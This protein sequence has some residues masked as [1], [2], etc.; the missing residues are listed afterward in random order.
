[1]SVG[2]WW[3]EF[4]WHFEQNE[5]M[6]SVQEQA[7]IKSPKRKG[8]TR[9]NREFIRQ[10]MARERFKEAHDAANRPLC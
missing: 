2:E 6:A 7:G 1:M 4:D 5:K 3:A 8:L 9:D 10:M